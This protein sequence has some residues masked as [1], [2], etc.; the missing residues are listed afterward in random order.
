VQVTV[1]V[2]VVVVA[3]AVAVVMVVMVM[4][5]MAAACGDVVKMVLLGVEDGWTVFWMVLFFI[6]DYGG[7]S[8]CG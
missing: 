6:R 5:V 8:S 1:T 4:G 3:A 7:C 2:V